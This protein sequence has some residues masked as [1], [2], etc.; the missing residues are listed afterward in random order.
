MNIIEINQNDEE[1]PIALRIIQDSPKKLYC[2]GNINLL[3]NKKISVVGSRKC[4]AYGK[5]IAERLSTK[6]SNSGISV[7]SGLARGIDSCAH[8][9]ALKEVGSTIAVLATGIDRCYPASN[10]G[11]YNEI[12]KKGLIIS[13]N[14]PGYICRRYDFPRRNRI[15]SGL[16]DAVVV[17]EAPLRSG[18]LITAEYAMEQGKELFA[19]PGNIT[20]FFSIGCNQLIREGAKPVAVLDDV[21]TDL[22]IEVHDNEENLNLGDDEFAVYDIIRKRGEL[23]TEDL[24]KFTDFEVPKLAG[25]LTVLEM[26]GAIT[27]SMGKFFVEFSKK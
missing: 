2:I 4:T 12:S 5:S 15:I 20:S 17:V 7:V 9:G 3:K 16:S 21:L 18:A 27:N 6:L 1:F 26:K 23:S 10:Q 25:I 19:I 24:M 13:E 14:P 8:N 22:N 11:I